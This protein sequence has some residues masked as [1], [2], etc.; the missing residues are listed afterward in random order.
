MKSKEQKA[1][2]F[3]RKYHAGLLEKINNEYIFTYDENYLNDNTKPAIAITFPK[4]EKQYHSKFL[5]PFFFG[6]LSEGVNKEIQCRNLKIDEKDYFTRLIKTAFLDT[7]GA[8][9]L[10]EVE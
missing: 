9:T 5:F 10:K 7:I 1:N 4:N 6:L 8:V 2:V 3:F